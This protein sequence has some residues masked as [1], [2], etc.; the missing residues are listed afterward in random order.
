MKKLALALALCSFGVVAEEA[1]I[2]GNVQSKCVIT[3]D[4]P[5]VYGNPVPYQL[6]TDISSGGI[7]PIVR[8]DVLAANNYKAV[9]TT[10]VDFSSAPPLADVVNWT[11]SVEVSEVTDANMSAYDSAKRTYNNVTEFDLTIAG[12]VWFKATSIADYGYEKSLPA[13]EYNAV[14]EAECIAL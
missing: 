5:G 12:T 1:P 13:G 9:I 11:G 4:T 14:V 3:T 8:Y 7:P 6:S 2:Y 10:P